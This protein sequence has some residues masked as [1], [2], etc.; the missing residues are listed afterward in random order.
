MPKMAQSFPS[1]GIWSLISGRHIGPDYWLLVLQHA[2]MSAEERDAAVAAFM[3]RA[4]RQG[5][6][7]A[8]R[9]GAAHS[10][11]PYLCFDLGI[12]S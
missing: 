9:P 10:P 4:E 5:Q 1:N 3:A 7:G 6:R 2:D 12:Q 11:A 8:E